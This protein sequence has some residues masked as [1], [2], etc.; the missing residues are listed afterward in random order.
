MCI[1]KKPINYNFSWIEDSFK[2]IKYNVDI[3]TFIYML[4]YNLFYYI[5]L[6]KSII[7]THLGEKIDDLNLY[8]EQRH[9]FEKQMI[10]KYKR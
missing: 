7:N 3:E 6:D 2:K 5:D 4:P 1:K 10:E 8:W 9:E